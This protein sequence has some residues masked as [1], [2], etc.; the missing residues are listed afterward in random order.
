MPLLHSF[1]FFPTQFGLKVDDTHQVNICFYYTWRI[2][3]FIL[4]RLIK[5]VFPVVIDYVFVLIKKYFSSCFFFKS[6]LSC[7]TLFFHLFYSFIYCM[8]S[9]PCTGVPR[10]PRNCGYH[11]SCRLI[12]E[13]IWP[14]FQ[15][16]EWI[17]ASEKSTSTIQSLIFAMNNAHHFFVT[18]LRFINESQPREVKPW[19]LLMCLVFIF[20]AKSY[21]EPSI[22]LHASPLVSAF[23]P[24]SN[25]QVK[26]PANYVLNFKEEEN[27]SKN[28]SLIVCRQNT[29]F[30]S[31]SIHKQKAGLALSFTLRSQQSTEV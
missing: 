13:Y 26:S 6:G 7:N 24:A 4:Y 8:E 28:K 31:L 12:Y 20:Q 18:F 3:P 25:L 11:G 16:E 1:I 9:G 29:R 15:S 30:S 14:Y 22:N 2:F 23:S 27:Y 19:C 17:N 21:K 5:V 10:L